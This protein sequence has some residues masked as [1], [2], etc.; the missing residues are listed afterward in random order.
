MAHWTMLSEDPPARLDVQAGD[1][2]A[3][4]GT[5]TVGVTTFPVTGI[6]AASGS[7]KGRNASA[8]SFSGSSSDTAT[9]FVAAAGIMDGPGPS[10]VQVTIRA[11]VSSSRDGT[12]TSYDLVMLPQQP[13]TPSPWLLNFTSPDVRS[14]LG[15]G[16]PWG[17]GTA[18]SQ[19][20]C[21]GEPPWDTGNAVVPMIGGDLTMGAIRDAFEAAI[22]DATSSSQPPGQRG[23]VYIAD[24]QFNALRDLS[25]NTQPWTNAQPGDK[26][27]TA[28][29][30]VCRM[31]AAGINVRLLLWMPTTVQTYQAAPLA[32]E[33]WSVAAA[34]QDYNATLE[35]RFG[36]SQPL[37][38][39]AL[40]LRTASSVSASLHQKMI[41]VRVGNVN[42]A[43]C[44]GVDLAFTRRD[45]NLVGLR[46][47]GDGDWQSGDT[48]PPPSWWSNM[49][50]TDYPVY[51]YPGSP[52]KPHFPD[53]LPANVYGPHP[54]GWRHWHDHHLRLQG[55]IV[56]TL[57][58]QFAERWVMDTDGRVYTFDRTSS[59]GQDDQ[60]QLTSPKAW[61]QGKALPL[62]PAAPC[63]AAGSS[64]VQ[65][66]RT[67]PMRPDV[68]VGPFVR[69]EFSVAAGVANAVKQATQL[70][71]VWDQYFWS[72]PV[73]RQL[74]AQLM[75][76]QNLCLL[77][78]LPPYGSTDPPHELWYRRRALQT[79]AQLLNPAA[80]SR[81][82]VMN[83]WSQALGTGVY[84][85]AKCQTYDESLLVCGSANMNRRSTQCDAELDCAVLDT[86]V[87]RAH[88]AN[89][90][91]CLTGQPWT[92]FGAGWLHDFWTGM[93][94]N[95][96]Q[97]LIPDPF[98]AKVQN[99]QTPNGVPMTCTA[100]GLLMP[101]SVFEPT[102]V[103]TPLPGFL[104][105]PLEQATCTLG[106]PGDPGAAGRLDE[107]SFLLER[108]RQDPSWLHPD[109]WPWRHA[110]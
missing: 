56:A 41:A 73:A 55:P 7:I 31:M 103:G 6:W 38:V 107:V 14:P 11:F 32:Y 25:A 72:E 75:A 90:Y 40:D 1:G 42:V 34:V 27:Q 96:S 100:P 83:M 97:T 22:A 71:T 29:G 81:V 58:Q 65:M 61:S 62:P 4:S 21:A 79:L 3:M 8:F 101:E 64:T 98:W 39:V 48:S 44:G 102:S 5:L 47:V 2:G 52:V 110:L 59:I 74:G 109:E 53:D 106:C 17:D 89:L 15:D 88:L 57:E 9:L 70:I 69:G 33:H 18:M 36:V 49:T 91:G 82:R 94:A 50:G 66:W 104:R 12:M 60:V 35:Q 37:G 92:Q 76:N 93:A 67:I 108:C 63:P 51:P 30:L 95:T 23:H 10:P 24:W 13:V 20:A 46:S 77:I 85:H 80:A 86:T 84:V 43:F 105:L 99:P 54:P 26:G 78:V 87:V 45:H 16:R 19:R 28:L 68:S